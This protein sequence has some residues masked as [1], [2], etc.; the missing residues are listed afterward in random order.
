MA[1]VAAGWEAKI[2]FNNNPHFFITLRKI[3]NLQTI[4][5]KESK[6]I[7]QIRREK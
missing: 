1:D 5:N 6:S 3:E 2:F 7:C 4:N